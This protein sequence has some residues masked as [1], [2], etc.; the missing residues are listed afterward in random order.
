M[1]VRDK[2]ASKQQL[3]EKREH[4][5]KILLKAHLEEAELEL[6]DILQHNYENPQCSQKITSLL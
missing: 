6:K 1:S 2:E 5:D 4:D 3:V